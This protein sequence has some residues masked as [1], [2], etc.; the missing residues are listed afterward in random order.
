MTGGLCKHM[1]NG[2]SGGLGS[3]DDKYV[4]N[5]LDTCCMSEVGIPWSEVRCLMWNVIC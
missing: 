3:D 5:M 4:S 2:I 1:G